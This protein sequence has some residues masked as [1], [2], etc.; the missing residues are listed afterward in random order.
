MTDAEL[1]QALNYVKAGAALHGLV[2][3]EAR[4]K[5]VAVHLARTAQMAHLLDATP[6]SPDDE[7]AELYRA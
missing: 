1:T 7:L 3:D 2:L 6:M 5:A 4:V